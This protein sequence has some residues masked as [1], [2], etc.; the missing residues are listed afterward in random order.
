MPSVS[1]KQRRLM[2]AA[3]H[4][5]EFAEKAGISQEIACEFVEAD[6]RLLVK[7]KKRKKK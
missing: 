1:E 3:C 4:S 6:K 5:K 7:N 2:Q